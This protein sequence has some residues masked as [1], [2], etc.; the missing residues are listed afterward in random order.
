MFKHFLAV[1]LLFAVAVGTSA[2]SIPSGTG[3]ISALG[4]SP[5]ILDA[6]VDILAN[7]AWNNYYRN[8]AFADLNPSGENDNFDGHAGVTF[9]IGKQLNLGMILNKRQDN[10]ES[11]ADSVKAPIVPFQAL[12]GYTASKNFHITLAPYVAMWDTTY[13]GDTSYNFERSSSSIGADLGFIYMLKKGWVEGTFLFRMNK[14]KNMTKIGDTTKTKDNDGGMEF[15]AAF[16]GWLYPSKSSKLSLVPL[17]GFYMYNIT[18]KVV[19]QNPDTTITE[20]ERKWMNLYGG[21][22]INWPINDDI[23]IA[24][25]VLAAYNTSKEVHTN[26]EDKLTDFVAPVFNL[27]VETRITDWITGRLGY[28]KGVVGRTST[29]GHDPTVEWSGTFPSTPSSINMGAGFHFGRFSIDATV[30]HRWLK[31]G[32]YFISGSNS[33][34]ATD[35]FGII[36]A[37]YNFG[38]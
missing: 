35:L 20:A 28:T 1:M 6:H 31:Q 13:S 2:Q 9:G 21:V 29:D 8:Y 3:R 36:S 19:R 38:K 34:N 24:G 11:Y 7:P 32:P 5:F 22:G 23:Q 12:I 4:G 33:D 16:R 17:L 26:H 30:S 27:A 37:S 25:G 18:P 14:Y 15:G 10:W